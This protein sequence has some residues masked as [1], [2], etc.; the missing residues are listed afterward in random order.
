[1]CRELQDIPHRPIRPFDKPTTFEE[2]AGRISDQEKFRK[3]D[4]IRRI[5]PAPVQCLLYPRHVAVHIADKRVER[6][7]SNL[8]SGILR[9]CR[10]LSSYFGRGHK[11]PYLPALLPESCIPAWRTRHVCSWVKILPVRI[12]IIRSSGRGDY[13]Q[14]SA[15]SPRKD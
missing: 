3:D 9:A 15:R 10:L 12:S 2:V 8:H 5:N 13:D 1:M 4:K 14:I 7:K 11:Y 6:G